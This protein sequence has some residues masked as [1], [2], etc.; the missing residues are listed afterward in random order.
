[1]LCSDANPGHHDGK[2]ATNR[3]SCDTA[4]LYNWIVESKTWWGKIISINQFPT[5]DRRYVHSDHNTNNEMLRELQIQKLQ[6]L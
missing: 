2:P 3:L 6:N 1:M 4:L 5:K